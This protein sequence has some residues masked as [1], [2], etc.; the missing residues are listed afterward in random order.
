MGQ[1]VV[2]DLLPDG[3]MEAY[4]TPVEIAHALRIKDVKTV[5]KWLR[6]PDHPLV[7]FKVNNMWRVTRT[8]FKTFLEES[9]K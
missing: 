3:P 5:L 2:P 9:N 8:A 1:S 7:G 6:N 4:L